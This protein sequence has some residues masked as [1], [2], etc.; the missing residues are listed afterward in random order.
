MGE[1]QST[2]YHGDCMD[3]MSQF[4]DKY[5]ELAIVDP[6][7]GIIASNGRS[8]KNL[9]LH[10]KYESKKWFDEKPNGD[11]F[12]ELMR[13]SKNQIIWGG[14]YFT[15]PT[16]RCAI[17]WDKL[18]YN[19]DFAAGELAWASFDKPL[20]IFQSARHGGGKRMHPTQKPVRL[21]EWLLKNYAK[22]GDKILDTHMGSQSSRIACHRYGFDYW[23]SEL[24]DDYFKAGCERF[25][26][27]SKQPMLLRV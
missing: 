16:Y 21:Y 20:K 15:L 2:V 10:D 18:D 3:F 27:E 23:G 4:P 22:E 19:S 17:V 5:F 8:M 6:P 13:V 14:N 1:A 25:K 12:N 7:Y 11:Y 26:R 9:V 24:D